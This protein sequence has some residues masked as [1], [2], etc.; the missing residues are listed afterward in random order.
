M[1]LPEVWPAFIEKQISCIIGVWPANGNTVAPVVPGLP[2]VLIM[3]RLYE[4]DTASQAAAGP[5]RS[6]A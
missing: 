2:G 4:P 6:C 1:G 5:D 3:R